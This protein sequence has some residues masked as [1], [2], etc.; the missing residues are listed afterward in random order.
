V[1]SNNC[2]STR[3]GTSG[4][5]IVTACT[6]PSLT[7]NLPASPSPVSVYHNC[8]TFPPLTIVASGTNTLKYQWYSSTSNNTASTVPAA[9]GTGSTTASYTPPNSSNTVQPYYFCKV[10]NDCGDT[11]SRVSGKH[12]VNSYD[13]LT[14]TSTTPSNAAQ[15]TVQSGSPFPQLSVSA[16]GGAGTITYQW[17]SN[18]SASTSGATSISGATNSSYTPPNTTVGKKYYYCKVSDACSTENSR[19]TGVHEVL[20]L[21]R[22]NANTPGWGASLGTVSFAHTATWPVGNQIWSAP[23]RA[24]N[25][26]KTSIFYENGNDEVADCRTFVQNWNFSG[27][28]FTWCAVWRYARELCPPGDGWRVPTKQD[29]INLDKALGGTGESGQNNTTLGEK[30]ASGDRYVYPSPA[31]TDTWYGTAKNKY[32]AG[33]TQLPVGD[34]A[35]YYWSC[36]EDAGYANVLYIRVLTGSY[37]PADFG[38]DPQ[39]KESRRVGIMLRCVK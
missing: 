1:V 23:V 5:L 30:Y 31:L 35:G 6:K 26:N 11:V 34:E 28:Y 25:C 20:E 36:T 8:T 14:V 16:S 39:S 32:F 15:T 22:C 12:T 29:F 24:T 18:S 27:D 33:S 2:G 10:T 19:F 17:Y 38:I 37:R 9:G 7:T 21:K 13:V 3:S 4:K